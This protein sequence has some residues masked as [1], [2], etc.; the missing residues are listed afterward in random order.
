MA[1][2]HLASS[3]NLF[4]QLCNVD[5]KSVTELKQG[6]PELL[7]TFGVRRYLRAK[8]ADFLF[9]FQTRK[10]GRREFIVAEYHELAVFL[11]IGATH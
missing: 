11:H 2:S 8:I 9:V 7:G 3:S 5:L 6:L 1:R 10:K 4:A